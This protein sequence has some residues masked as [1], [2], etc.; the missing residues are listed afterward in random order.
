VALRQIVGMADFDD[1]TDPALGAACNRLAAF[2][3][4]LAAGAVLDEESGLTEDD[5]IL[6]LQHCYKTRRS[7][8]V[9]SMEEAVKRHGPGIPVEQAVPVTTWTDAELVRLYEKQSGESGDG[10]AMQLLAEIQR[11]GLDI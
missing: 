10:F 6:I 3:L 2:T 7:I 4:P 1:S 11:R 9:I 5:L 8:E